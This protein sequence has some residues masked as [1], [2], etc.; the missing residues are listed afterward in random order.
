M[1]VLCPL[2][3]NLTFRFSL[4]TGPPYSAALPLPQEACISSLYEG[5]GSGSIQ[6]LRRSGRV[7]LDVFDID[8]QVG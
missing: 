6:S 8:D 1:S 7:A 2:G 3:G 5:S 4:G